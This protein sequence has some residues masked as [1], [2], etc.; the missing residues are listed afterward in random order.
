M[1]FEGYSKDVTF[2]SLLYFYL[3]WSLWDGFHTKKLI[4]L[5]NVVALGAVK[6]R[7]PTC[8]TSLPS[9]VAFQV[10][11]AGRDRWPTGWSCL[12]KCFE[13]TRSAEVF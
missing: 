10:I 13:F 2:E 1:T 7:F 3:P 4:Q 6:M 12:V 5:S 11:R 9:P 8:L